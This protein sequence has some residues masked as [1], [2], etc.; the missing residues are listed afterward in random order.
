[1]NK[2]MQLILILKWLKNT[3]AKMAIKDTNFKNLEK[4]FVGP[5]SV[6]YSNDPVSTS[7]VLVEFAKENENLKILGGAMGDKEL[8][9]EDIKN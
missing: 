5:T 7:K 8:S 1:M 2:L 6:A 4:V 9:I 3:L